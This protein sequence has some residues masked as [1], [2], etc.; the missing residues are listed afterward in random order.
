MTFRGTEVKSEGL[1]IIIFL[2]HIPWLALQLKRY[3][4]TLLFFLAPLAA[5]VGW[6]EKKTRRSSTG[7]LLIL[8]WKN[9][10]PYTFNTSPLEVGADFRKVFPSLDI[11]VII[12]TFRGYYQRND[13]VCKVSLLLRI[14][15]VNK[16]SFALM[17]AYREPLKRDCTDEHLARVKAK[18]Q[19][20]TSSYKIY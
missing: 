8:T 10:R 1:F 11:T 14:P 2:F 15:I 5:G 18:H 17:R 7:L 9:F 16:T 12:I 20:H 3:S 13:L 4:W 6:Y 19:L